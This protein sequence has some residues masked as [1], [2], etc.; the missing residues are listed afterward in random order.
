[1]S[2]PDWVDEKAELQQ[3]VFFLEQSNR[4]LEDEIM[5]LRQ[6]LL[7]NQQIHEQVNSLYSN[8]QKSAEQQRRE[9]EEKLRK[10]EADLQTATEQQ[11][12][13]LPAQVRKPFNELGPA[14]K[15]NVKRKIKDTFTP[16]LDSYLKQRKLQVDQIV[17]KG[18]E[19][20]ENKITINSQA[21][22]TY[23][24]LTRAECETLRNISDDKAIYRTSGSFQ[25]QSDG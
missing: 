19:G 13:F 8:L 4:G 20:A 10:L 23:E 14:Q 16:E 6:T 24:N 15:T 11:G 18:A 5:E 3:R 1:M 7:Y 25:Q 21:Q 17:L 22:N 12:K 2:T 9:Y